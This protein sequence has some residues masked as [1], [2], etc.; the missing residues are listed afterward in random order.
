MSGLIGIQR[1]MAEAGRIRTGTKDGNRPVKLDTFR[2]TSKSRQVVEAVAVKYGGEVR[3]WATAPDGAQW[4]VL[5]EADRLDV[6]VLPG[7]VISQYYEVW[8]RG[9][10]GLV[11]R[12]DGAVNTITGELCDCGTDPAAREKRGAKPVT[13]LSVLLTGVAVLG[14]FRLESSGF[15]AA[16]ELGGAAEI[17]ELL[18]AS[19]RP[20][21]AAL[22]LEQRSSKKNGQVSRYSVPVL[23]LGVSIDEAAAILGVPTP[24]STLALPEARRVAPQAIEAAPPPL[25]EDDNP[26]YFTPDDRPPPPPGEEYLDEPT[27]ARYQEACTRLH[28]SAATSNALVERVTGERTCDVAEVYASEAGKLREEFARIAS[29]PELDPSLF[30]GQ[31]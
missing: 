5:T 22:R 27:L 30:E 10:D 29:S 17:L 20:V 16:K 15:Y 24:A 26:P 8:K 3:P 12:C 19:N 23:D 21:P 25:P 9:K 11:H 31:E 13:R 7:Q 18:T 14:R 2:I 4:E 6:A 28:V 1:E